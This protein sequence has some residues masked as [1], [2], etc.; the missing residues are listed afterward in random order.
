MKVFHT[1]RTLDEVILL[2]PLLDHPAVFDISLHY[3]G[4]TPLIT[5][6][7]IMPSPVPH[8]HES[9]CGHFACDTETLMQLHN[10]PNLKVYNGDASASIAASRALSRMLSEPSARDTND[11]LPGRLSPSPSKPK[12]C[13][14]Y[15]SDAADE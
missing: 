11:P 3:T 4:K 6:T 15:T 5:A 9:P 7:L 8:T 12:N 2:A 13:L 10:A 14:L 1:A